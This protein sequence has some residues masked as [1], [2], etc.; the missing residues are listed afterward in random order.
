MIYFYGKLILINFHRTNIHK[1]FCSSYCR[2]DDAN[3]DNLAGEVLSHHVDGDADAYLY[4][5][6]NG[7]A[8]VIGNRDHDCWKYI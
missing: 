6:Q 2:I 4:T 8:V 7:C 1:V 5:V 3:D